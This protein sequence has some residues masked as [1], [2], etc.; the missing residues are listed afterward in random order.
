MK[1]A[2]CNRVALTMAPCTHAR[3]RIMHRQQNSKAITGI[4]FYLSQPKAPAHDEFRSRRT[5]FAMIG[6]VAEDR[7][8]LPFLTNLTAAAAVGFLCT[9][10]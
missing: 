1:E 8:L 10:A 2:L 9:N 4:V 5:S 3:F 7:P 6:K